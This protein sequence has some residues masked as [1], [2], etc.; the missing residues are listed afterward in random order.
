MRK[1]FIHVFRAL[2]LLLQPPLSTRDGAYREPGQV[3]VERMSTPPGLLSAT[4]EVA[5]PLAHL[6]S[7]VIHYTLLAETYS[8]GLDF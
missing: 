3:T 4:L 8:R 2:D 5:W 6:F 7:L 1:E